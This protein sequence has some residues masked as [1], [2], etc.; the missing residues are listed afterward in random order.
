MAWRKGLV[1]CLKSKVFVSTMILL[2]MLSLVKAQ[3]LRSSVTLRRG[4]ITLRVYIEEPKIPMGGIFL[5]KIQAIA[6]GD[7]YGD[8][9]KFELPTLW[10]DRVVQLSAISDRETFEQ[11]GRIWTRITYTYRLAPLVLGRVR[12][13]GLQVTVLKERFSV[14]TIEGIVVSAATQEPEQPVGPPVKVSAKVSADRAFVGE[15]VVY[16]LQFSSLSN[17]E[18][19]SQP[20][21]EAPLTEGFWSEEFP[22]ISRTYRSGYEIQLVRIALFPLREG[23]LKIGRAKVSVR[24]Q[25][26]PFPEELQTNLVKVKVKT[27]P[28]P[29]PEGFQNLVGFVCASVEVLPDAVGVGETLTVNLKVEGTANLRNLEQPPNLSVPNAIVGLP[30]S[31]LK[32]IERN[33]KL[34]FI[35]KFTWRIVPQ[36]EGQLTIPSFR[37]PYFDPK[38]QRYKFATTEPVTVRVFPGTLL[39]TSTA[40]TVEREP[41]SPLLPIVGAILLI[42][43]VASV[44]SFRYFQR[45]KWLTAVQ[46]SDPQLR[47]AVLTFH[48]RGAIE[49]GH[50]IRDWLREQIYQR[51]G[52]L[53]S[54]NDPSE[55]V[56][57]LLLTKGVSE[58]A[59]RAIREVWEQTGGPME[60]DEAVHLLR[61]ASELP[62]R[63]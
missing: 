50:V 19:A 21:Y 9:V 49:F 45:R 2:V 55:K 32:A 10:A 37:I 35:H 57:Q 3:P 18:F 27:L 12:F 24:L 16:T 56:Q 6:P 34:W 48:E 22:K 29:A 62:Q 8:A 53:L 30:R 5:L 1:S 63:L 11:A 41:I 42:A 17:A 20:T 54:P 4:S 46:V 26:S 23:E 40:P 31:D 58:A 13:D 7:L 15:Q 38:E 44:V 33:G 36:K 59:V 39:P 43:I 14:P 25:G 60:W 52:V 28:Q 47:Q 51:T 61:N